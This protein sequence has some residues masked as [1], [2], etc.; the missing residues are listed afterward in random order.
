[1][2]AGRKRALLSVE[3]AGARPASLEQVMGTPA[4][5]VDVDRDRLLRA[6]PHPRN[7]HDAL[8]P[9]FPFQHILALRYWPAR[10][11]PLVSAAI[12]ASVPSQILL[13]DG[14]RG[15]PEYV[16]HEAGSPVLNYRCWKPTLVPLG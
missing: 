14:P 8:S 1:M 2:L 13:E 12:A 10:F 3:R 6:L 4:T 5:A 11:L 7:R 15:E 9:T 16:G